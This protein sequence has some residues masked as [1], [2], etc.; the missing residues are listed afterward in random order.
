MS[1]VAFN[2]Q[3]GKTVFQITE[4]QLAKPEITP[5]TNAPA[6]ILGRKGVGL[7]SGRL[8]LLTKHVTASGF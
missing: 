6:I 3:R 7:I 5:V 2:V 4:M 1:K 8:E